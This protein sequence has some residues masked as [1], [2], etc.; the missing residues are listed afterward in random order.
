MAYL[1]YANYLME[2]KICD[3]HTHTYIYLVYMIPLFMV[4]CE[5]AKEKKEK[6][7]MCQKNRGLGAE[8]LTN[9]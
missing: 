5:K 9:H 7:K 8:I 3:K 4:S 1:Q 2:L 6:G